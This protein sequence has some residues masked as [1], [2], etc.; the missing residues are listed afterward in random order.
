MKRL[1]IETRISESIMSLIVLNLCLISNA[2]AQTLS[3]YDS[4]T[5]S[6]AEVMLREEN[7]NK[8]LAE[9]LEPLLNQARGLRDDNETPESIYLV[10]RIGFAYASTQGPLVVRR[11]A[12]RSRDDIERALEVNPEL[13]DGVAASYLG[14]LYIGLPGWP[15]SIGDD[16]RGR[17]LLEQGIAVNPNSL[18]NNYYYTYTYYAAEDYH[19]MEAQLLKAKALTDPYNP[20]PKMEALILREIENGLRNVRSRL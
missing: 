20:L 18:T 2:Q 17:E 14:W 10:A 11:Q 6:Y 16:E 7:D 5:E 1:I 15:I 19:R 12:R 9:L 3:V 4:L 8:V 13:L